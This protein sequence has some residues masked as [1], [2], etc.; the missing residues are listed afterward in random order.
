[1][2]LAKERVVLSVNLVKE[3]VLLNVNLVKERVVLNVTLVKECV[4]LNMNL[5]KEHVVLSVTLVKERV[6]LN[7][8]V[9]KERAILKVKVLHVLGVAWTNSPSYTPWGAKHLHSDGANVA[10]DKTT[11]P[12]LAHVIKLMGAFFSLLRPVER[13]HNYSVKS[14]GCITFICGV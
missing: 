12:H 1:M 11:R 2:N 8:N 5:V 7:V 10:C 9:V 4:D 3:R 13:W 14:F 6:D